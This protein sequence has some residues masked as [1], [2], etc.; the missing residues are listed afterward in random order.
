MNKVL[1]NEVIIIGKLIR[2][3]TKVRVNNQDAIQLILEV[4]DDDDDLNKK[5]RVYAY[6]M[7]NDR[8]IFKNFLGKE[9]GIN[10]HIITHKGT[11]LIV[12]VLALA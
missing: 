12:D 11:K 9:I 2:S 8:K 1:N 5:N 10:G 4:S 7:T 6:A 3:Y